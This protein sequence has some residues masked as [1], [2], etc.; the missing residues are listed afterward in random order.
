VEPTY[1]FAEIKDDLDKLHE[2]GR[3]IG[4]HGQKKIV[5]RLRE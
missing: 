3:E 2:V 4:R 5:L 1:I